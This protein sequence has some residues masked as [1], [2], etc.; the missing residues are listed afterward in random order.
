MSFLTR[1]GAWRT[2]TKV[3]GA[4]ALLLILGGAYAYWR[5]HQ[6]TYQFVTVARGPLTESVD[7]TGSVV[8]VGTV[9]LAF[10]N[11]G[12]IT[13]VDKQVGD[14]VSEG[15]LIAAL[16]TRNLQTQLAAA[17]ADVDAA[18]A[19]L[20]ALKASATPATVAVSQTALD[21]AKRTLAGDYTN[22]VSAI[23]DS[24]AK[25][26]DAVRTKLNI[27]FTNPETQN[28]N[29]VF[30]SSES[31]AARSTEDERA[32][33]NSL[34]ATWQSEIASLSASSPEGTV[35]TALAH[36]S[37][38]LTAIARFLNDLN[39]ATINAVS[40]QAGSTLTTE[41]AKATV[42]SS[43]SELN[44]A[45]A[46]VIAAQ[47]TIATQASV[48]AQD[49]AQLSKTTEPATPE[50]IAAQQAAVD[51]ARA[52][53]DAIRVQISQSYL[54]SPITGTVSVQDAKVGQTVATNQPVATVFSN[55]ALEVD[56]NLP[57]VDLGK[58]AAGNDVNITFDAFPGETFA[59]KVYS[60]DPA[61]TVTSGVVGYTTKI[62]FTKPDPRIK[63]GLTANLSIVAAKKDAVLY[64]PQYAILQT[65]AGS[66]VETLNGSTVVQT[67]VTTGIRDDNGNVEVLSGATEG[68][69]VLNIGLKSGA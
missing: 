46:N 14:T 30:I 63:S 1:I 39:T 53:A 52:R 11:T 48:V 25:A 18:Q 51:A 17:Q 47:N 49:Q 19:R 57:E 9:S 54:R 43:V 66:F 36:A 15:A 34:F 5:S 12:T 50:D 32:Q 3:I 35:D 28:P 65:D 2:R 37:D 16:D 67:P 27:F 6:T 29:L 60:I 33:I 68:E 62:H 69:Q 10:Q 44:T 64:L 20:A 7:L 22:G 55:D 56:V 23:I 61:E 42:T 4:L 24:Y 8:P 26:N 45:I 21:T 58:V 13:R 31:A 40:F 59:G 38:N 41:T